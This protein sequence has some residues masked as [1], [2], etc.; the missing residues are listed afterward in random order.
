MNVKNIGAHYRKLRESRGYSMGDVTND[1]LN[2]SQISRF[3]NGI[4]M[5]QLDSFI[6]AVQGLNMTVSEFFLTADGFENL[7]GQSVDIMIKELIGYSDITG[8]YALIMANPR[9]T[10]KRLANIQ[11]KCAILELSG[12]N[13]LTNEECQFVDC[14]L[15]E[16]ADWTMYEINLLG[17]C[18]KALDSELINMLGLQLVDKKKLYRRLPEHTK[19]VRK[20]LVNIYVCMVLRRRFSYAAAFE[21]ELD[22]LLKPTDTD[23]KIVFHLFK[24]V[25]KYHRTEVPEDMVEILKDIQCLKNHGAQGLADRITI[26]LDHDR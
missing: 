21:L 2:K 24:K 23:E 12:E 9:T 17:M 14:Y 16:C 7:E 3:E 26:F 15:T 18:L 19:L 5:L 8:L 4:Q 11:L 1:Y 6:Y 10:E 25:V 20:T 22:E 13:L